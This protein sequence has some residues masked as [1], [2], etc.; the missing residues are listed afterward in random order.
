MLYA[1]H[2]V[3]YTLFL[4]L[5]EGAD[6]YDAIEHRHAEQRDETHTCADAERQPTCHEREHAADSGHRDRCKDQQRPFRT[7]EGEEQQC[8][9]Q[10]P[11]ATGTATISRL[12]AACRFSNVP[13]N[14]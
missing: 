1:L 13:P 14:V 7:V 2:D 12:L 5:I 8:E 10:R 4:Q 11:R 6:E 9:G 3:S